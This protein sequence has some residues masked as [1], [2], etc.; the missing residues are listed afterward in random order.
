MLVLEYT[1][2]GTPSL[3]PPEALGIFVFFA[4]REGFLALSPSNFG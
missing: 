3:N 2:P 4:W 1:L